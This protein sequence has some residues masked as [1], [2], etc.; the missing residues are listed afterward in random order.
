M[1]GIVG[2][3]GGAGNNLTRV[4][5]AMS[6]MAYRAP[7]STGVGIFGDENE[8]VRVRRSVGSVTQLLEHLL[9]QI[10]FDDGNDLLHGRGLGRDFENAIPQSIP[11]GSPLKPSHRGL[12]VE[13]RWTGVTVG[14]CSVNLRL[15]GCVP[16]LACPAVPK[17]GRTS[18]PCHP[19]IEV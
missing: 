3:F 15:T 6:A 17:H 5:T 7:D 8:T 10:R 9:D 18:Q 16:L 4:L 19:S 1:C 12:R 11:N 2:Y 13:N 14:W